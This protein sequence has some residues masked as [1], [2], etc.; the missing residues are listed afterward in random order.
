MKL[1]QDLDPEKFS[2][3]LQAVEENEDFSSAV[4]NCIFHLFPDEVYI[5]SR[6][7][8]S[9]EDIADGILDVDTFFEPEESPTPPE[10]LLGES[11]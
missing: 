5:N 9:P 6:Y 3:I 8:P 10:I 2:E 11:T 7:E 4:I 1:R